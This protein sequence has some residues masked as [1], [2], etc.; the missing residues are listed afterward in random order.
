MMPN[1]SILWYLFVTILSIVGFL[2]LAM[3]RK[4]ESEILLNREVKEKTI[5][6]TFGW[7]F[8]VATLFVCVYLW[9]FSYGVVLY[10]GVLIFASLLVIVF[11]GFKAY[12]KDTRVE[13]KTYKEEKE[14]LEDFKV[15]KIG[16][17]V[18]LILL[19]LSVVYSLYTLPK[20]PLLGEDI[21]KDKVGEFEFVLAEHKSGEGFITPQGMPMQ[22]F[23]LKFCKE[24]DLKIK[25]AYLRVNKPRNLSNAGI[26]FDSPY[27]DKT[28]TIQINN[29]NENSELYLTVIT[30]DEQIYQKAY[31]VKEKFPQTLKWLEEYKMESM[32]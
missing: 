6:K 4:R 32:K 16:S 24:C 2:F 11:I 14:N 21:I 31:S 29:L 13:N 15:C 3:T 27:W 30:K 28:S 10:I 23:H 19:P 20:H 18:A 7:A 5:F 22:T 17:L 8:L 9:K 25:Y 1:I 26:V 12:K